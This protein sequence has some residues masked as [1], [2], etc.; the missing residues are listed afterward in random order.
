MQETLSTGKFTR[1]HTPTER[2]NPPPKPHPD[3]TPRT[4]R[5][6]S[7]LL[8]SYMSVSMR[9]PRCC[10]SSHHATHSFCQPWLCTISS[11]SE[12]NKQPTAQLCSLLLCHLNQTRRTTGELDV[13][14]SSLLSPFRPPPAT[15]PLCRHNPTKHHCTITHTSRVCSY[16]SQ[17]SGARLDAPMHSENQPGFLMHA[18]IQNALASN[19]AHQSGEMLEAGTH[20]T[21]TATGRS[22]ETLCSC[23]GSSQAGCAAS[24]GGL[25]FKCSSAG[26]L[27][28]QA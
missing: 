3:E 9:M 5:T 13:V 23:E 20:R 2:P 28:A 1:L 14:L 10:K 6:P 16:A 18:C 26:S 4:P 17:L 12:A 25:R 8:I 21:A 22:L 11:V 24:R 7:W 27:Y 15:A 19:A